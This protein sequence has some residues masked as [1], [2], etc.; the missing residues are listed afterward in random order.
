MPNLSSR[1]ATEIV[2]VRSSG[3]LVVT[4]WHHDIPDSKV[5]GADMGPIWGRQDP[6]VPRV[7]PGNFAIWYLPGFGLLMQRRDGYRFVLTFPLFN[8]TAVQSRQTC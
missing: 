7:G 3:P 6:G 1:V 2:S 4:K 5:H 8:C